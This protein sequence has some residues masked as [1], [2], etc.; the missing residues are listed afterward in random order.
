MPQGTD[1][2]QATALV[3]DWYTAYRI[4]V[5]TAKVTAGQ[6]VFMHGMSGAVGYAIM[7]FSLRQG[8]KVYGTV[9]IFG[10][11]VPLLEPYHEP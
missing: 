7:V 1:L 9:R 11:H 2:Q 4:V 5:K 8:A 3:V 10:V 6:K